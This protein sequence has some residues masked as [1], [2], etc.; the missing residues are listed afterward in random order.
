MI[1]V[2][3]ELEEGYD[4]MPELEFDSEFGVRISSETELQLWRGDNF[5]EGAHVRRFLKFCL[6]FEFEILFKFWCLFLFKI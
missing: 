3:A 2:L 1:V 6:N 4:S 5:G